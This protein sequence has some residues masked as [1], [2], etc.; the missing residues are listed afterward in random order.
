M[1]EGRRGL[2]E[3]GA[4]GPRGS[5]HLLDPS[6]SVLGP[7]G[8]PATPSR[9]RAVPRLRRGPK[10]TFGSEQ[11]GVAGLVA[12][13]PPVVLGRGARREGWHPA[14][15]PRPA[16]PTPAGPGGRGLTSAWPPGVRVLLQRSHLRQN[17]CQSLPR[18]LTF[19]AGGG[20][21]V[22]AGAQGPAV[23]RLL[24]PP[25]SPTQH[26]L[27]HNCLPPLGGP[28]LLPGPSQSPSHPREPNR[29]HTCPS[30]KHWPHTHTPSP[31]SQNPE[32]SQLGPEGVSR[33]PCRGDSPSLQTLC[34]G[35]GGALPSPPV[36]QSLPVYTW[37]LHEKP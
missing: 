32:L 1:G 21:E 4:R 34:A 14:R 37:F 26:P 36:G 33:A 9:A 5:W 17:L 15:S 27:S 22:R 29:R 6:L 18:E 8:T 31:P 7:R 30:L 25:S 23:G 13:W 35:G 3:K 24:S 12:E 20:R 2:E 11:R 10:L 28:A 19:S 16:P